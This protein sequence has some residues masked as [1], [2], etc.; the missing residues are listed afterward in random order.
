MYDTFHGII[1]KYNSVLQ[2]ACGCCSAIEKS[3]NMRVCVCMCLCVCLCVHACVCV[4]VCVCMH[5]WMSMCVCVCLSEWVCVCMHVYRYVSMC[6]HFWDFFICQTMKVYIYIQR[7][8][9]KGRITKRNNR[10]KDIK[11]RK[12]WPQLPPPTT[13]TTKRLW[14]RWGEG[15]GGWGEQGLTGQAHQI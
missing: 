4:C 2:S 15:Q 12:V 7:N 9:S 11:A 14:R 13:T 8:T 10:K 5:V 6:A 1:C 3:S